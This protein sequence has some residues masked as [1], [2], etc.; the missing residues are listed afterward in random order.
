VARLTANAVAA[1]RPPRPAPGEAEG[2]LVVGSDYRALGVVRSLGRRGIPVWVVAHGDDKLAAASRYAARRL[3][4]DRPLG[5]CAGLLLRLAY[6]HRLEGWTIFPSSDE[7]AAALARSHELLAERFR[8][9]VPP[10]RVLRWAYDKRLMH[11]LA[12]RLGITSP[13][14][15]RPRTRERVAALDCAF[16][17]ALK[18]AVKPDFNKLTAAKAWRADDRAELL[19]LWDEAAE[20]M[21]P[22]VLMVQ[23][24]VPGGGETQLSYA[25]VC[26]DGEVLASL[27]ARR[28]RQFP[29][30]FGRAS[31]LVETIDEPA[32]EGPSRL[33][34]ERLRWTGL[35]EVE[36]KRD[37]CDGSCKLLDVNPRVWGWHTLGA[38]AGVD[39]SYLA[40]LVARGEPVPEARARAG[41][42][43][44]RM[45]TDLP[46]SLK[47]IVGGRM[48]PAAYLRSLRRPREGAIFAWDDLLPGALEPPQLAAL[49]ARRLLHG[50]SV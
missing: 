26:R 48:S 50:S 39:F 41:V 34:L 45:S 3:R 21:D 28:T 23:E 4:L 44:V 11:G 8:M 36:F 9:T 13:G 16:P 14:T 47:E 38:R 5:S 43:W 42:R 19:R 32:V 29:M 18:P 22:A 27:T 10:W 24:L 40:W 46:T 33:L 35:V 30:D 17:V 31:T 6:E 37:P 1:F 49:V 2:A 20:L 15:H 25:A 12:D 7:S